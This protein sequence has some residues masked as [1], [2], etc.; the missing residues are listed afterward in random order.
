MFS[1]KILKTLV[2]TLYQKISQNKTK[3]ILRY[4]YHREKKT[5]QKAKVDIF[6]KIQQTQKE[7]LYV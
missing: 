7:I 1:L 6:L 4:D 3:S 2:E 5:R